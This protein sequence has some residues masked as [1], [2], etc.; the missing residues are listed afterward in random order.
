MADA[1]KHWQTGD[2]TLMESLLLRSSLP[3]HPSR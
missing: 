3:L 2:Y 1:S